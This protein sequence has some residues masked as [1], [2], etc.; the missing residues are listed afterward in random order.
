M[1]P[2]FPK[3]LKFAIETFDQGGN[4]LEVLGRLHNRDAARAADAECVK[5]YPKKPIMLCQGGRILWR[6]DRAD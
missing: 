6:S 1:P 4:M 3:D 2:N 5:K